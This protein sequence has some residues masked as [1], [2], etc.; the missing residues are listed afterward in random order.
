MTF[1]R[2]LAALVVLA[3]AAPLASAQHG[4]SSAG[5]AAGATHLGVPPS[6]G[7]AQR[8]SSAA[9]RASIPPPPGTFQAHPGRVIFVRPS[10]AAPSASLGF[11]LASAPTNAWAIASLRQRSAFAPQRFLGWGFPFRRE[12]E[13]AFPHFP[14]FFFG[15]GPSACSPLLPGFFGASW[16]DRQFTCFGTPFYGVDFYP[17]GFLAPELAYE[18]WLPSVAMFGEQQMESVADG[19]LEAGDLDMIASIAVRES[20]ESNPSQQ[21]TTLVL[22]E[23]IS[24]G[25]IDYWVDGGKLGYVTTF[26]YQKTIDLDRLDLDKTVK[27]NSSRGIPFVLT[28]RPTPSPPP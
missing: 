14:Y 24:F 15:G 2:T 25:V 3:M 10:F 19:A 28:E 12:R 9:R 20:A 13:R 23:G 7:G 27:L 1:V 26:G 4:G 16:F 6:S 5:H 17:R 21:V 22:K 8:S 18:P 11:G